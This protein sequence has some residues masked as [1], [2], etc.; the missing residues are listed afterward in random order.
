MAE[1]VYDQAFADERERLAGIERLWDPATQEIM[2][3]LGIAPGWRCLEVGAGGGSMVEWMAERV[4]AGGRVLA[5]DVYTKFL[6]AIERPNVEVR[7]HDILAGEPLEAEFDLVYA[8]LVVEHLGTGALRRM[9]EAVRPGGILLL[10]DYDWASVAVD[11]P[12]EEFEKVSDAVLGLMADAGFDPN[13]GRRLPAELEAA[14]LENVE[15]DGRVRLVRGGTPETAFFRLSV[16]SLR[17]PL[18]QRDLLTEDE[19]DRALAG[20]DD[21]AT[22]GLSPILVA[23]WGRRPN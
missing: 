5:T 17:E 12:Q 10:E 8:R 16:G 7:Q 6:E 1:Y 22:T 20:F 9:A 2:M 18:V 14:G 21:P 19:I 11:P 23:G 4:G 15:A 3:R 13:F